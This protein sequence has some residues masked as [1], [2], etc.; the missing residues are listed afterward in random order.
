MDPG[1]TGGA[2]EHGVQMEVVKQTEA[3]RGFVPRPRRW[4]VERSFACL[5]CFRRLACIYERFPETFA[6]F[7]YVAFAALMLSR[8]P[9][10]IQSS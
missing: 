4:V 10:L 7:H 5:G 8:H 1:Y 2:A 6:A 3:K 9:A